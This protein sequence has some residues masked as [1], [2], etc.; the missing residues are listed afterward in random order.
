MES[1]K[2]KVLILQPSSMNGVGWYRLKQLK[3]F[4][5]HDVAYLSSGLSEEATIKILDIADIYL[6][7]LSDINAF[8]LLPA[9]KKAVKS[10]PLILDIDDRYDEVNP[11][12]DLYRVYGTKELTLRDGTKLWEDGVN[13]DIK[14]NKKR[15]KKFQDLMKI[16]TIVTVTTE[17]LLLYAKQFNDNVVIVPNSINFDLFPHVKSVDKKKNEVRI[18]WAGG[19][20]HYGDLITIQ[21]QLQRIMDRNHNVHFYFFGVPFKGITKGLPMNRV[22]TGGWVSADG[23]GYR[24]A[25]MDFDIGIAPLSDDVFNL[26]KSS[27]KYYE[28][29]ALGKVT[30]AKNM[31]PYSVDI[32]DGKNGFLY[33]SPR[34]FE[35]K[36]QMLID[37][38]IK[39]VEVGNNAYNYVK[40]NFEIKNI[41]KNWDEMITKV[42]KVYID[43]K[44]K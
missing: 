29:S 41:V 3:M 39:R 14:K 5:Q 1:D 19:S 36:L 10:K 6:L 37:D 26:Y 40:D 31:L 12:S 18:L 34:E 23:H 32:T 24:L 9:L 44:K 35:E 22:H 13:I 42:N 11:L 21:Q 7:R 15:L 20:S 8:Y 27:I 17:K 25:T 33:K 2:V 38:P 30:L 28:Y 4:S 16:A 43:F